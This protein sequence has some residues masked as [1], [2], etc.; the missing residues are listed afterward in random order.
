MK[1]SEYPVREFQFLTSASVKIWPN[2]GLDLQMTIRTSTE[3]FRSIAPNLVPAHCFL[4]P[5]LLKALAPSAFRE[6]KRATLD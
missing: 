4:P 6:I 3:G 2:P 1:T 5:K